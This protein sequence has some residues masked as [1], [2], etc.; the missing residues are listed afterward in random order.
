MKGLT[1]LAETGLD[2][3]RWRTLSEVASDTY[4]KGWLAP[5]GGVPA[6]AGVVD[7]ANGIFPYTLFPKGVLGQ[8]K[9]SLWTR[10]RWHGCGVR[11]KVWYSSNAGSVATFNVTVGVRQT[12]AGA[13]LGAPYALFTQALTPAGPA[14]ALDVGMFEYVSAPGL[15]SSY[16]DVISF[17]FIRDG[18][19]DANAN[20]YWQVLAHYEFLEA[21]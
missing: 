4:M 5:G 13:N 16:Y 17:R 19:A 6:G 2:R 20:E 21:P 11:L 14:V 15:V 12:R 1:P 3:E 7:D 9:F 18:A 10:P 8:V